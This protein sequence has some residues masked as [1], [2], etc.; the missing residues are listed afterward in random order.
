MKLSPM[1][2]WILGCH[3][4]KDS[5]KESK[6]WKFQIVGNFIF[7]VRKRP[8]TRRCHMA[9]KGSHKDMLTSTRLIYCDRFY[10]ARKASVPPVGEQFSGEGIRSS[11]G[12]WLTTC[13]PWKY[14]EAWS[15]CATFWGRLSHVNSVCQLLSPSPPPASVI[16]N[17]LHLGCYWCKYCLVAKDKMA[18][19]KFL[20]I[21]TSFVV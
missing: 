7:S 2:F 16:E 21:G 13:I 14:R 11:W 20:R 18:G 17:L 3:L 15:I 1:I 8:P 9:Q 19:I 4:G 12:P 5:G 6:A 10:A